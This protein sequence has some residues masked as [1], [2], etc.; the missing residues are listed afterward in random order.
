MDANSRQFYLGGSD[1][2]AIIGLSPW[3]T[4]DDLL[5]EKITGES[6]RF[7]SSAMQ[8]GHRV[9]ST[10]IDSDAFLNDYKVLPT[11]IGQDQ[12]EITGEIDGFTIKCHLDGIGE[13]DGKK[14]LIEV[15]TSSAPF[16]GKLPDYYECQIQFYMH[17][18]DLD[19]CRVVFGQRM[20][21]GTLGNQESFVVK[22]Q[23]DWFESV[24]PEIKQFIA[25][26]RKG[27]VPPKY[28]PAPIEQ[29]QIAEYINICQ[30]YEQAQ[31]FIEKFREIL[32]D[33]MAESGIKKCYLG[34]FVASL[35]ADSEFTSFDS[36]KF[37]KENPDIAA[38]Y[39]KTTKR[40]GGLRIAKTNKG[41]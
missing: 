12:H 1:I 2:A 35:T 23:A 18:A 34:G 30:I 16:N 33:K 7:Y 14:F 10:L 24:L 27:E 13:K 5:R 36:A 4:R 17:W 31:T 6:E 26:I 11:P 22:K 15:K 41:E 29:T 38:K 32:A 20:A 28:L 9:E 25:D 39:E 21:D 37:K 3:A 8:F 19:E 40:K